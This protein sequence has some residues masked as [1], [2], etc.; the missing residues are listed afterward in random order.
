MALITISGYPS[1]GKSQRAAQLKRHLESRLAD[2]SYIGPSLSVVLLSDDTLNIDRSSYNDSRSEKPARGT[3]FTA[4]QRNLAQNTIVI[5]DSLNYIKG[6]RYQMYCAARE[7]KVRVCTVYV[8]ATPDLCKQWNSERT[9]GK[10]YAPETLANLLQRYEEP[11]SM[12]RW[13]SPLFTVSWTDEDVPADDIWRAITEGVVKPPNTGTQAVAKAPT[14][15]LRTLE[16][17]TASIVSALVS[18]QANSGSLGGTAT[19]TLSSTLKVRITLPPRNVTLS[20]L[21]RLKRQFVTLHK[22]A[23]TLGT[24]EKGVVDWS[25]QSVAD[26]FVV[27]FEENIKQ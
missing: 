12:V 17:T 4:V 10:T 20:E 3:L 15:A 23:I 11:S 8:L 7:I 2:P 26:K 13:D 18:E 22:R 25:E 6:F 1:S 21:Q 27:Y 9:D 16:H 14:D 24:T 19:I 5:V